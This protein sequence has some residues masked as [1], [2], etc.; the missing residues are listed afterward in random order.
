MG[1]MRRTG[2]ESR[3]FFKEA[4]G[5]RR[6]GRDADLV[7]VIDEG[8]IV[9][10]GTHQQLLQQRGVYHHLYTSQFKGKSI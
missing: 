9:E 5:N 10:Q 1:K 7:V 4:A 2:A 8:R 6:V 3:N